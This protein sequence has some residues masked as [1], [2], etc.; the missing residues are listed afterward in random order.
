MGF[1]D[2]H[3]RISFFG[4]IERAWSNGMDGYVVE[5]KN[6]LSGDLQEQSPGG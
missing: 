1:I 4:L 5:I 3:C 6:G 2:R